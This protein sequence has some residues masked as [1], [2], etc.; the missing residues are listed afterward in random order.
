MGIPNVCQV[1]IPALG[2]PPEVWEYPQ[3]STIAEVLPAR[4]REALEQSGKS[5]RQLSIAIGAHPGY[6]RDL[7]DPD[8]F[9]VPSATRLQAIARELGLSADYL[10][11]SSSDPE[12]VR[13]EVTLGDQRIEWNGPEKS[14][15]PI[16][17]F[18]TGDCADLAVVDS[19]TGEEIFIERCSFDPEFH[20]RYVARP[21]AL[22]GARDIYAIYFHGDSMIPRFEPGEIGLVDPRRP[23]APGDDV[24]V[25]LGNGECEEVSSVIAKRLVRQNAKE[26]VLQ[27]FNP[28]LTFAIARARVVRLHRIL[29]QTD[30]L[31]G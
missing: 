31:F 2:P 28:P 1:G 19:T 4:L 11:G 6:I 21:P 10:A 5:M 17:I 26:V 16:P 29:R 20:V 30:M 12:Q 22:R 14:D 9:N 25:Q 27:Q 18:G 13:S 3:V 15:P 7:L 24:L 23:A 8:R